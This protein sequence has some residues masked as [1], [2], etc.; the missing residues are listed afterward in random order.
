MVSL[1]LFKRAPGACEKTKTEQ[2]EPASPLAGMS[3]LGTFVSYC[4]FE[5]LNLSTFE[6]DAGTRDYLLE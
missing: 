3:L 4:V 6:W 2:N 5:Q 1:L